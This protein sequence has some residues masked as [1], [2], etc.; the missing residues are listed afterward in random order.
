MWG[1]IFVSTIVAFIFFTIIIKAIFW[2]DLGSGDSLNFARRGMVSHQIWNFKYQIQ[3]VLTSFLD[4]DCVLPTFAP[5]RTF[6]AIWLF[7]TLVVTTIYRSKLV[8]LLAFPLIETLP[9]TFD[10]L[11]YSKYSVGF[12][13]HGDSAYNT[14]ADSTDPVYVKLINEMEVVTGYGLEC[15]EKV[16]TQKYGCIAYDFALRHLKDRNLSEA[17]TRKLVFAPAHTYNI[18]LGLATEGK[19]ILRN[20][21]GKWL[22]H[23][24]AFHLEDVWEARDMYYTVRVLKREWWF[25]TNQS[26]KASI[27]SAGVGDDNLTLKHISGS[28]YI[29]FTLLAICTVA[30]IYEHVQANWK[31]LKRRWKKIRGKITICCDKVFVV[32]NTEMDAYT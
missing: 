14:L 29:L 17:D 8:S 11:A 22:S 23:T 13:K 27:S 21:F 32:S 5:L 28:F 7:F 30:F 4:Q 16:V 19:S 12:M 20:N 2:L 24:R 25:A 10:D 3:F 6:V 18:Y 31:C 15:L 9:Q 1:C 26:E